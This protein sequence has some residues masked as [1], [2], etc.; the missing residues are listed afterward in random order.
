MKTFGL[1]EVV[2]LVAVGSTGTVYRARHMELDR[3]AA[4]K[5]LSPALRN[6]PG[7]LERMRNEARILGEL[8][9]V[10]V[11]AVYDY[12]EEPDRAWIAEEWVD[13]VTLQGMLIASGQ[14]TP[15]QSVGVLR[16]AL[17]GLA[18]AHDR[19]V[20]HRDISPGNI[21]ADRQGTSKL[22]DFGLA[23][24]VGDTGVCGTPA[25]VSP[26][27]ARGGTVGKSSDVYSA[28]SVLFTLLSGHPPFRAGDAV[29]V[30][31]S[32]VDDPPPALTDHG[33]RLA[34]LLRRAMAKDPA[35]RPP[36][37]AAFLAELEDAAVERWGAGWLARASIAGLVASTA[38]GAAGTATAGSASAPAAAVAGETVLVTTAAAVTGAAVAARRGVSKVALLASAAVLTV[39]AGAAGA[40]ALSRSSSSDG[41]ADLAAVP[42]GVT[43]ARQSAAAA[44]KAAETRRVS[45]P[46]GVYTLTEVVVASDI[47]GLPVGKKFTSRWTLALTCNPK[48]CTGSIT[49]EDDDIHFATYDGDALV[50]EISSEPQVDE[51]PCTDTETGQIAPDTHFK[52]EQVFTQ[53][54]LEVT[55]RA[56]A[57][58]GEP[59]VPVTF[60]GTLQVAQTIVEVS[61]NCDKIP[62]ATATYK[63]TLTKDS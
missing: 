44:V 43:Q 29:S 57:T 52:R 45:A 24:P 49:D 12:V 13:G 30:L 3:I 31:R 40:V 39:A 10:H 11:V 46:A 19:G 18:C 5:E 14:L 4:I 48:A 59:G 33:V 37:A 20:V 53:T 36:D 62:P 55:K 32:H 26:E 35:V 17:T 21:I 22:V 27:A 6:V 7:Q 28:A 50:Q 2:E 41:A 54:P 25:Y 61:K 60:T 23:A 15:E 42:A 51:G 56:A 1:Y 47:P 63:R 8:D 16:G 58:E 38:A 9:N 34:D